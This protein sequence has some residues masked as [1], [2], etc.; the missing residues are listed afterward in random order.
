MHGYKRYILILI[1]STGGEWLNLKIINKNK[2]SVQYFNNNVCVLSKRYFLLFWKVGISIVS[3]NTKNENKK[4]DCW[5][6]YKD[7]SVKILWSIE[8]FCW[9]FFRLPLPAYTRPQRSHGAGSQILHLPFCF[10]CM[11]ILAP[12]QSIQ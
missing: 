9:C 1:Y 3:K 12:L 7:H 5:W 2:Y 10:S 6:N 11:Q 4:I 8:H